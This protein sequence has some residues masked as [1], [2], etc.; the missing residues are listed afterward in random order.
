[1]SEYDTPAPPRMYQTP[2]PDIRP[3]SGLAV[4][5]MVLGI[6]FLCLGPLALLPLILGIIGIT[7]TGAN[8]QKKGQGFAIA[9]TAL[10]GVGL[11]GTCLSI[12]I[13]LPAI[14][15]ARQ[16]AQQTLSEAQ[17]NQLIV[18]CE[19]YALDN[20]WE[21]PAVA[22]WEQDLYSYLGVSLE[23]AFVSPREYEDGDGVS[24]I[25]L[26]GTYP[27]E[28]TH[29]LFYEDP[30]HY[31]NT[32]VLVGFVDSGTE[33]IPFDIFEQMLAEQQAEQETP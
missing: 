12:G 3:T 9:G 19:S 15:A 29:I 18:A 30:K 4:T 25:Y 10:G 31:P 11:M 14:G 33:I 6:L 28:P 27:E 7:M 17:L 5:S 16:Q 1:M 8:G 24:Y 23:E 32:G 13:L 22:T 21:Y 20:D 2:G 26:G